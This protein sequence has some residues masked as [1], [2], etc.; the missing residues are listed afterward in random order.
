MG[1]LYNIGKAAEI[2]GVS[3][4]TLRRWDNSGKFK[5]MRHPINNYPVPAKIGI[6]FC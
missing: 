5:S 6:K 2:L 3:Q 4:D 1:N